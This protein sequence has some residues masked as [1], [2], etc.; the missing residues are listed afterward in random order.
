MGQTALYRRFRLTEPW[1]SPHNKQLLDEMPTMYRVPGV[2]A[3]NTTVMVFTGPDTLYPSSGPIPLEDIK[4]PAYKTLFAIWAAPDRAVPWTKPVDLD[5]SQPDLIG[6]VP[7][8]GL[9]RV[10]GD[11]GASIVTQVTL[12]EMRSELR[13]QIN[14]NDGK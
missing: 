8:I 7:D 1:D 13:A 3:P 14:P 4:D 6:R 10:T 12:D 11:G 9:V 5:S 2:E